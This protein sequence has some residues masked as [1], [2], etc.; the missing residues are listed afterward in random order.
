MLLTRVR[1][2]CQSADMKT[3][4]PF[5]ADYKVH[6]DSLIEI[7]EGFDDAVKILSRGT[8]RWGRVRIKKVQVLNALI[9]WFLRQ[10]LSLQRE[11]IGETMPLLRQMAESAD[12]LPI[13]PS[14]APAVGSET[15]L[16]AGHTSV[17][18]DSKSKNRISGDTSL[19]KR[20]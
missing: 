3:K 12:P 6:A 16:A 17:N 20:R 2:W 1:S 11:I 19:P 15:K 4:R 7:R 8:I 10:P 13:T 9:L 14:I 5:D 18:R